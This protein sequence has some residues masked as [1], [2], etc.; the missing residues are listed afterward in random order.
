[1]S[2][3]CSSDLSPRPDSP[4]DGRCQALAAVRRAR[5]ETLF[6]SPRGAL[7]AGAL[8]LAAL[9]FSTRAAALASAAMRCSTTEPPAASMAFLAPAE[10]DQTTRFSL[11]FSSPVP[12]T[13]TPSL[14]RRITP[15]A[16]RAS[17]LI[18]FLA[19]SFLASTASCRRHRFTSASF[20]APGLLKPRFGIRMYS[21]IWPP[22]KPPMA[23]PERDFWPLTPRPPV[24]PLP[25]PGPRP[26]RRRFL[27]EPSLSRTSFSF[28][29]LILSGSH[30]WQRQTRP[31]KIEGPLLRG[32]SS[33]RKMRN[34]LPRIGRGRNVLLLD[35]FHHVGDLGD[36]AAHRRGVLQR[37]LAA[38]AVQAQARQG[39]ALVVLAADRAADLTHGDGLL[40][41]GG[42]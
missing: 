38:H 34:A 37:G 18:S 19:S 28:I 22:S 5:A 42:H 33:Y 25:E 32:P 26:M 20:S 3:V 6:S 10:A 39:G 15:A 1:G 7:G 14:A 40:V 36:H 9:R 41:L 2:D 11:A 8:P 23:T 35:H 30:A 31:G 4:D 24:L 16:T 29:C 13:R 27:C 21:G 12:R 17:P